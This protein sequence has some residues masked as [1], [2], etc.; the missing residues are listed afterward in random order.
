M[1]ALKI[2]IVDRLHVDQHRQGQQ[3]ADDH[4]LQCT[5][6]EYAQQGD[7]FNPELDGIQAVD[8]LQ[9][10]NIQQPEDNGLNPNAEDKTDQHALG[11]KIGTNL[12]PSRA[13]AITFRPRIGT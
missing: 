3:K 13:F 7:C 2:Y 5:E 10:L 12:I 9:R 1:S 6:G 4:T 8:S 11:Q